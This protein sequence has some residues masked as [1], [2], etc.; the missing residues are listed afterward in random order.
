MSDYKHLLSPITIRGKKYKNRTL[1]APTGFFSFV[2]SMDAPY[3]NM[4]E[5]R[6]KGGFASVCSGEITVNDTDAARGFENVDIPDRNG[7]FFP[8]A[9]KAASLIKDNGALSMM[10]LSHLGSI[11]E[12]HPKNL[13]PW[14]LL[15]LQRKMEQKSSATPPK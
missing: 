4:L 2:K 11:G 6:S 7:Q 3:Y 5:E 1:A 12:P 14:G 10:E 15:L 8:R 13:N 9:R